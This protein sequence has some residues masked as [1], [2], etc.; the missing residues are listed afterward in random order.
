MNVFQQVFADVSPHASDLLTKETHKSPP[1][2][3]KNTDNTLTD[4]KKKLT[5]QTRLVFQEPA[6]QNNKKG[7]SMKVRSFVD[8]PSS[9]KESKPKNTQPVDVKLNCENTSK[10]KYTAEEAL[11]DTQ[12]RK[13]KD[14]LASVLKE[15]EKIRAEVENQFSESKEIEEHNNEMMRFIQNNKSKSERIKEIND[16]FNKQKVELDAKWS[17][18]I[19][20]ISKSS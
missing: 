4:Q 18:K 9:I 19:D 6:N 3:M 16:N 8:R 2:R 5:P 13:Q 7:A 10:R 15:L 12:I 14:E 11:I 20:Q 17:S 1:A